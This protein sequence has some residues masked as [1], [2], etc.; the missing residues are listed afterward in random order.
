M[1]INFTKSDSKLQILASVKATL[2]KFFI[3][4]PLCN[5]ALFTAHLTGGFF[6]SS[7]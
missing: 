7:L 3:K 4:A 5:E 2:L 6:F 1:Y